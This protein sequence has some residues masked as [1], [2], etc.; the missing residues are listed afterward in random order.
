MDFYSYSLPNYFNHGVYP[1]VFSA[2]IEPLQKNDPDNGQDI[3]LRDPDLSDHGQPINNMP[4]WTRTARNY[5]PR[6]SHHRGSGTKNHETNKATDAPG[7]QTLG[8]DA[9]LRNLH[10][11][12]TASLNMF[13]TFVQCFEADVEPL[14][15][16]A[17]EHTLGTIWRNKIR[18]QFFGDK[19]ERARF[20]GVAT[21]IMSIRL[22]LKGAAKDT[23]ALLRVWENKYAAERQLRTAK[24]AV[25]FCDGLIDLAGRTASERQACKQLLIELE[26]TKCLLDRR[27]HPWIYG[28]D[29]VDEQAESWNENDE[30]NGEEGLND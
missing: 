1:P 22:A 23:K 30:A 7:Y 20:H 9:A 12:V 8:I 10:H 6:L 28:E 19:R 24:K 15:G 4:Y 29:E 16:W 5:T 3:F 27:K 26:D 25:V 21:R 13:H 2:G 11:E 17:D 18:N 14:K